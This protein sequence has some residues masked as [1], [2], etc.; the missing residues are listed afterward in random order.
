MQLLTN[1]DIQTTI[2]ITSLSSY[3]TYLQKQIRWEFLFDDITLLSIAFLLLISNGWE[4]TCFLQEIIQEQ[5]TRVLLERLIVNKPHPWGLLITFIELIKVKLILNVTLFLV[6]WYRI[7]L[8]VVHVYLSESKI[9]L[10]E[11]IV[12]K[13]CTWDWKTLWIR[14][15]I[16]WGPET[17][18]R[19]YGF[20]LGIRQCTLRVCL[21]SWWNS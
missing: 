18:G 15:T 8:E 17:R 3:Y 5:I 21:M 2:H 16:M 19:E 14:C 6:F 20:W 1:C 7:C 12:H 10:L 9:Q 13:V 11:S 4:H